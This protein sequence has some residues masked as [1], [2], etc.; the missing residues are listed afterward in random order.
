MEKF[1][2]GMLLGVL[3]GALITA[4][5]YKM[6][7]LIRKGQQEV[8]EKVDQMLDEKIRMMDQNAGQSGEQAQGGEESEETDDTDKKGK[9]KGK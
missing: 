4:N 7:T 3:G 8:Q 5:N 1:A 6:R 2:I 9:K